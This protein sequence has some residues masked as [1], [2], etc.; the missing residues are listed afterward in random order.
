M[1]S[2]ILSGRLAAT[3]VAT[4]PRRTFANDPRPEAPR[5]RKSAPMV[6]AVSTINGAASVAVAKSGM[7]ATPRDFPIW[8]AVLRIALASGSSFHEAGPFVVVPG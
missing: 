6:A 4:F 1:M 8:M 5:M 7:T 2:W 3:C